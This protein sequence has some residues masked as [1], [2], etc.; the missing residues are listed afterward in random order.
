MPWAHAKDLFSELF[1]LSIRSQSERRCI[2]HVLP[3]F[4]CAVLQVPFVSEIWRRRDDVCHTYGRFSIEGTPRSSQ[5]CLIQGCTCVHTV[6]LYDYYVVRSTAST[7]ELR[8]L[9]FFVSTCANR[10]ISIV[11]ISIPHTE[12]GA[13]RGDTSRMRTRD[14]CHLIQGYCTFSFMNTGKGTS[15]CRLP[16]VVSST[17][18]LRTWYS[19]LYST[20]T[21]HY[22]TGSW[23]RFSVL[24]TVYW[25]ISVIWFATLHMKAR[26]QPFS[27]EYSQVAL[28]FHRNIHACDARHNN[29]RLPLYSLAKAV[30]SQ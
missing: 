2:L 23:T 4:R 10:H 13:S 30:V 1:L 15:E 21:A 5:C 27:S 25:N 16:E 9:L 20:Q 6:Y 11:G 3:W 14:R 19:V 26:L 29:S 22:S 18:V 24:L 8:R 28:K 12:R 17:P 7:E